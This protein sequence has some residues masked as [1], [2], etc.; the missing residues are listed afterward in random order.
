MN[1]HFRLLEK[2]RGELSPLGRKVV[3]VGGA[4]I[5][6]HIDDPAGRRVR[7]TRDVD[8]VVEVSGR[9]EYYSLEKDLRANGFAQQM[10]EDS[11][12][13]RWTKDDLL[14]DVM[15]TDPELIGF[16]SSRWFERGFHNARPY[17]LPSGVKIEAFDAVHLMAA[18]IELTRVLPSGVPRRGLS[19]VETSG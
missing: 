8:L 10:L 13:C 2:A 12:I 18:K 6:L 14:V 11:P 16:A 1:P 17:E 7:A 15:P 9:P 19:R 3:F 5:S 4:T